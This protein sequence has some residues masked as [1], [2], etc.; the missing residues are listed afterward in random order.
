MILSEITPHGRG[1]YAKSIP[2]GVAVLQL[3]SWSTDPNC[4]TQP[5]EAQ[6]AHKHK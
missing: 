1:A 5:G 4:A 6:H 2:L 3:N